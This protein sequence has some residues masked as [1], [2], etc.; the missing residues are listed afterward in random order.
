MSTM[1]AFTSKLFLSSSFSREEVIPPCEHEK[2]SSF[3][4]KLFKAGCAS[5]RVLWSVERVKRSLFAGVLWQSVSV[6]QHIN[7]GGKGTEER[8]TVISHR[9]YWVSIRVNLCCLGGW[10][11]VGRFM[12]RRWIKP[13][14]CLSSHS[15]MQNTSWLLSKIRALTRS[16]CTRL[17]TFCLLVSRRSLL[18]AG[19]AGGSSSLRWSTL[20]W[21]CCYTCKRSSKPKTPASA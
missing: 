9:T 1:S 8:N 19:A 18:T 14:P 17:T 2:E 3:P 15:L 10:G 16:V 11:G 5:Q 12:V 7:S 6:L 4:R 21:H 13:W 20:W